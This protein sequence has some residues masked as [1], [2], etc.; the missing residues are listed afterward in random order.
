MSTFGKPGADWVKTR[1]DE[2]LL[3][4]EPASFGEHLETTRQGTSWRGSARTV[5]GI[6]REAHTLRQAKSLGSEVSTESSSSPAEVIQ[7]SL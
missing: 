5:K 3:S 7:L 6:A 4:G 2:G 1:A